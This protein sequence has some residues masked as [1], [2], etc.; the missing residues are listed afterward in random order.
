MNGRD[1]GSKGKRPID[2]SAHNDRRAGWRQRLSFPYV[3]RFFAT[4]F[5]IYLLNIPKSDLGDCFIFGIFY[6]FC[7]SDPA[8]HVFVP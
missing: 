3:S 7:D 1:G 4:E 6:H 2:G 5:R 8:N